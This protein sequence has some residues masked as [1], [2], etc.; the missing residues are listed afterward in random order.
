M[1]NMIIYTCIDILSYSRPSS[2]RNENTVHTNNPLRD[3]GAFLTP[4]GGVSKSFRSHPRVNTTPTQTLLYPHSRA[5]S[6]ISAQT[7][8]ADYN[9]SRA[10]MYTH[11]RTPPTHHP[12]SALTATDR[13][14][15]IGVCAPRAVRRIIVFNFFVFFFRRPPDNPRRQS[16]SRR[17]YIILYTFASTYIYTQTYRNKCVHIYICRRVYN[18][19]NKK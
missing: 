14:T 9:T 10:L 8:S 1:Y 4:D 5:S 13:P 19:N 18:N 2:S 11:P 7:P 12:P 17:R 6:L 15:A 3:I 16:N